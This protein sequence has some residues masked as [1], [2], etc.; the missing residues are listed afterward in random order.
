MYCHNR[1]ELLSA[2][3]VPTHGEPARQGQR[4]RGPER[5]VGKELIMEL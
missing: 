3:Q 2:P 1:P 4:Q 5:T